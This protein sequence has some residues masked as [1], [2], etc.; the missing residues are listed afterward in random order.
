MYSLNSTIWRSNDSNNFKIIVLKKDMQL[1]NRFK[2][3]LQ[4]KVLKSSYSETLL[5]LV[6]Y[7]LQHFQKALEKTFFQAEIR[8]F[9]TVLARLYF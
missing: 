6:E 2:S 5:F 8:I 7:F 4:I 9:Y 3:F 1:L